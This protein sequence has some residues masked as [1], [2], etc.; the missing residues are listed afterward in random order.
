MKS[1]RLGVRIILIFFLLSLSLLR[2]IY[3]TRADGMLGLSGLTVIVSRVGQ[4]DF[5]KYH[6]HVY[7]Q[8]T[9]ASKNRDEFASDLSYEKAASG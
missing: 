7:G 6:A 9:I 4:L 1:K 5:G 8:Y 3:F 2:A